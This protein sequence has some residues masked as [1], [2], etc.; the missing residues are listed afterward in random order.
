MSD[1]KETTKDRIKKEDIKKQLEELVNKYNQSQELVQTH[2]EIMK[3]CL[4]AI[5]VLQDMVKED[6][7]E[8]KKE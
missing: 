2:S 5:E 1:K 8:D 4:G 6:K 7:E 3:R